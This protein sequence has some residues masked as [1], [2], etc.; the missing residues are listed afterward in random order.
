MTMK[1]NITLFIIALMFVPSVS[2]AQQKIGHINVQELLQAMPDR[3]KIQNELENY[4]SEL[5]E[6][7]KSMSQEWERKI[8]D[9]QTNQDNMTDVIKQNKAREIQDLEA[10]IEE[11]QKTAQQELL[12]K[13]KDLM[14]PFIEESQKAIETVSKSNG[15]AYI[16][17]ISS[18]SV[19]FS[20]DAT[21]IID[22]VKKELNI[23]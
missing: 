1:K 13:E 15:Y 5:E 7:I 16:L 18:G 12:K 4:K 19:L 2:F 20:S 6:Q 22:L 9:F 10:R 3:V 8:T 14:Q 11:F 21:N 17:D 23:E